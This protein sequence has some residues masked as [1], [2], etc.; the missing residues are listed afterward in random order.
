MSFDQRQLLPV[1]LL[2]FRRPGENGNA[3]SKQE[4]PQKAKLSSQQNR[5]NRGTPLKRAKKQ[6]GELV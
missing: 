1:P 4:N 5:S 3:L 6:E 2:S